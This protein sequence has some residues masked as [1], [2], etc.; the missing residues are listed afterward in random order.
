MDL[1]QTKLTK[2]EWDALEVP[3]E[4]KEKEIISLINNSGNNIKKC[5]YKALSLFSFIK[6]NGSSNEIHSY[7]YE[8]YFE[9]RCKK[10]E[11]LNSIFKCDLKKSKKN[12]LKKCDLIRLKNFDRKIDSIKEE[13]IEYQILNIISNILK[14]DKKED[15]VYILNYVIQLKMQNLNIY[16][17]NIAENI[18]QYYKSNFEN[19][20]YLKRFMKILKLQRSYQ[21]NKPI[22]LYQHQ[23][24]VIQTCG[25]SGSKLVLYQAPTGTG[26]TLTPLGLV[27]KN[28]VIFVCAAK[29]IGLQLAKSCITLEI[30]IAVA[31]GCKDP[32]D[33]RLHYFAAKDYVKNRRTGGIFRVDNSV[34][35]KV[36]IIISDIQSYLPSMYYMCA[37]NKKE[38]IV[39]YWDEPTISLDQETHEFHDILKQNWKDN[40]IPNVVLSSA[41]LPKEYELTQFIMTFNNKFPGMTVYN[42]VSS[43]YEKTIP[44]IDSEGYA[45]LPHNIFDNYERVLQCITHIDEYK[46]LLRHFD[47][48]EICKFIVYVHENDLIKS[49]YKIN[50]YFGDLDEINTNSLKIYYLFIIKKLKKKYEKVYKHFNKKKEKMY[51]S[52]IK[53]T[54]SDAYTLTDGPTIFLTNDVKKLSMFYLKV[55]NISEKCFNEIFD[56]INANNRI[57]KELERVE[58]D[59]E[60]R[61]E[62]LGSNMKDKDHSKVLNSTEHK[63]Q[64]EYRKKLE[65]LKNKIKKIE[66]SPMY[67]PNKKEHQ[68]KWNN[69]I[70][71]DSFTSDIED[72]IIEKIMLLKKTSNEFKIL[73]MMGI[74]VFCESNDVKY[75]EIMKKLAQEQKLYLIIASSDYIYGTNY[76]FCHGYLSKDLGNISQEKAIQAFGRVGRSNYQKT[77]TIRLRNDDLIEKLFT[78]EE[79]KPEVKNMNKLFT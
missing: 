44:I 43:D 74:G 52:C 15:Y 61:L 78:K 48:K 54:T 64:M 57:L 77:Y 58:K 28:K 45:V 70:K 16:V 5:I 39:L 76:Q 33:I 53:I 50:N 27:K 49:P 12:K 37:F 32:S 14:Q 72:D 23:K 65:F 66:L 47:I 36:E 24:E 41:T 59:E 62:K 7:L 38:D 9:K 69:N 63:L 79:N 1:S 8:K 17:L 29:H 13:I 71:T 51:N 2:E 25:R 55:S 40:I 19:Y 75:K 6:L 73:L 10:F 3:I 4:G 34:G 26:K 56:N 30:P 68:M 20:H 46:T 11:K 22:E 35:D 42:V 60:Q 31:F 21:H 18:I 67:V